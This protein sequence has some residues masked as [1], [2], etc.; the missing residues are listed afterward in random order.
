V[1]IFSIV[2]NMDILLST[3]RP[4]WC[5]TTQQISII[6]ERGYQPRWW[7]LTIVSTIQ[8]KIPRILQF[9]TFKKNSSINVEHHPFTTKIS[10]KDAKN[11]TLIKRLSLCFFSTVIE[12]E[13]LLQ[14][15]A[16]HKLR[17][18][19]RQTYARLYWRWTQAM[20]H[21]FTSTIDGKFLLEATRPKPEWISS[22]ICSFIDSSREN[23]GEPRARKPSRL[24]N[25]ITPPSPS[26]KLKPNW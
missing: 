23:K 9:Q 22:K 3:I 10:P 13:R 6:S 7:W 11:Q 1:W 19:E 24:T 26:V 14:E 2:V 8:W 16:K 21:E 15:I 17:S 5:W 20:E 25:S 4:S 12:I 18:S